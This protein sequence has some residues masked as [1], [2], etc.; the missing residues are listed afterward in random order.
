MFSGLHLIDDWHN[1]WRWS[2]MRFIATGAAIQT[3]LLTTPGAILQY[4]PQ[5]ILQGLSVFSLACIIAAGIG[6]VTTTEKP[7]EPARP[8]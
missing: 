8:N 2:S 5:W 1:C 3:A 4:V 7:N 6:R